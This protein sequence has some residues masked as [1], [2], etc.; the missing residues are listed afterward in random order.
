MFEF[1]DELMM[2]VIV[3]TL[4]LVLGYIFFPS[5]ADYRKQR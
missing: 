5:T 2:Y 4:I 1:S 3:P